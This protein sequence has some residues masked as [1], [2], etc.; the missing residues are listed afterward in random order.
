MLRQN[1]N[2]GNTNNQEEEE[3]ENRL[4]P[5][6]LRTTLPASPLEQEVLDKPIS[7][8]S[9]NHERV[10]SK[11][12]GITERAKQKVKPKPMRY[13]EKNASGRANL[14]QELITDNPMYQK[15]TLSGRRS[16]ELQTPLKRFL[17]RALPLLFLGCI[18]LCVYVFIISIYNQAYQEFITRFDPGG[19]Y[20]R[21]NYDG[22]KSNLADDL[23]RTYGNPANYAADQSRGVSQTVYWWL[24]IV[25]FLV[26]AIGIPAMAITKITNE[27]EKMNW[28]A[29][30]MSRMSPLQV[31]AGKV[32]PV[33]KTLGKTTLALLPAIAITAYLGQTTS[34]YGG[35]NTRGAI[36]AQ[37]AILMTALLNITIA[38]YYSLTEKQSA[39]AA[40]KTGQWFAIPTLGTA[41]FSGISFTLLYL[42]QMTT[43]IVNTP[44]AGNQANWLAP[45]LFL[46]NV[47]NPIFTG[48]LT[49]FPGTMFQRGIPWFGDASTPTS[50]SFL[51]WCAYLSWLLVPFL[52]PLGCAVVIRNLCK[53]MM[54]KF[55]DAPKDASG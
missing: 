16:L 18:Y 51:A 52:Y 39:K 11:T 14:W 41:A 42:F 4:R 8:P 5:S 43:G 33:L 13:S 36:L 27:R 12:E 55:Q 2:S 9:I 22:G 44:A 37:V 50:E 28:D 1:N 17:R 32:L 46:P 53:K 15:E 25:Q 38:M 20:E 7:A 40:L 19:Y 48:I 47:I 6:T 3:R 26:A 35:L 54:R 21:F 49:F 24:L 30:L 29:L 45:F 34:N 23:L 31:L 10:S